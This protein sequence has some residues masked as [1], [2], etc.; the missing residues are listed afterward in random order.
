M[1]AVLDTE[2]LDRKVLASVEPLVLLSEAL[3]AHPGQ[4]AAP[5]FMGWSDGR[6]HR[7][8]AVLERTAVLEPLD[9][10][11]GA[12]R[13]LCRFDLVAVDPGQLDWRPKSAA[14]GWSLHQRRRRQNAARMDVTEV[15][16]AVMVDAKPVGAHQPRAQVA[17]TA[18]RAEVIARQPDTEGTAQAR[19]AELSTL[20]D[21]LGADL[22]ESRR[23]ADLLKARVRELETELQE[24]RDAQSRICDRVRGVLRRTRSRGLAAEVSG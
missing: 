18:T 10:P 15:P 24:E 17:E 4:T 9:A 6:P 14:N 3:S 2:V 7:V 13:I 5:G 16:V 1:S 11:A 8:T 19:P 21:Q 22:E 20:T 12:E 23:E